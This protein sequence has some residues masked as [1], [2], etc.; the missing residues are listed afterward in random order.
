MN[1]QT[2]RQYLTV[3]AAATPAVAGCFTSDDDTTPVNDTDSDTPGNETDT[4]EPGTDDQSDNN[5]REPN[6][7]PHITS[8]TQQIHADWANTG[9]VAGTPV[10]T[11]PGEDSPELLHEYEPGTRRDS[12]IVGLDDS[13]YYIT[14][15]SGLKAINSQTGDVRYE[16][17]LGVFDNKM[18][19]VTPESVF[20]G[21][22]IRTDTLNGFVTRREI[23]TG[24]AVWEYD[25]EPMVTGAVSVK[26]SVTYF[27]DENGTVHSFESD[28]ESIDQWE[29]SL[30][31]Q[32]AVIG[33]PAVTDTHVYVTTDQ[34]ITCLDVEMGAREWEATL[35][36]RVTHSPI[37]Y[38]DVVVVQSGPITT[39]YNSATGEV[40]WRDE[41]TQ[42]HGSIV[43]ANGEILIAETGGSPGIHAVNVATGDSE[44]QH[45]VSP[46]ITG[47]MVVVDTV[48]Y[49]PVET[50]LLAIG[51][52]TTE[53]L[54]AYD[55]DNMETNGVA[56]IDD[57]IVIDT[58]VGITRL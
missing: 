6:V 2:R 10:D 39:V 11:H 43:T 47:P 32:T 17:L 24:D 21:G 52:D 18:I 42:S 41:T 45:S 46:D 15:D 50:G 14:E 53:Q 23:G 35:P 30:T 8:N 22:E 1:Q 51:T 36:E 58:D 29:H 54:W 33:A 48:L 56:V 26:D 34:T 19:A 5:T 12:P 44:W 25:L 55:N 37:A 3:I 57:S 9:W 4:P 20:G 28:G 7:T 27:G 31:E 49:V 40:V 16:E 38:G 13:L